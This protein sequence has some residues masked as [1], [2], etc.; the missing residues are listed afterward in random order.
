MEKDRPVKTLIERDKAVIRQFEFL[1]PCG[2]KAKEI[3]KLWE[4]YCDKH[5]KIST[6]CTEF[7]LRYA[8]ERGIE[9][10]LFQVFVTEFVDDEIL[11]IKRMVEVD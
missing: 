8:E 1:M 4:S 9:A 2:L 7:H 10:P 3:E 5:C 11:K 6:L